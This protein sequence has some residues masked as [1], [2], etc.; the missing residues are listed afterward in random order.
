MGLNIIDEYNFFS[1][2][3]VFLN[4]IYYFLFLDIN[5]FIFLSFFIY[6]SSFVCLLFSFK[7][8][9]I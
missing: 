4:R 8:L 9:V 7:C 6:L 1:F 3:G 5:G 2:G